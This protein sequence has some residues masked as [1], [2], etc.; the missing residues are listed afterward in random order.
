MPR[1]DSA[2]RAHEMRILRRSIE[3]PLPKRKGVAYGKTERRKHASE[4]L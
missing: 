4:A 3:R 1:Q 2:F